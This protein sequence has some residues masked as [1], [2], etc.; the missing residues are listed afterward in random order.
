MEK[1]TTLDYAKFYVSKGFP[2][3]PCKHKDKQPAIPSWK[4]YQDRLPSDDELNS[5]FGN[6][7]RHNIAIITG[8]LSGIVAVDL[9]S[10]SAVEFAKSNNFPLSPLSKTGK[11]Y[12]IIYHY[13]DGVRNFQKRDDL[14]GIDLR[15]EGGYICVEPSIHPSGQHYK[16][17]TGKGLDDLPLAELPEMILAKRPEDKTPLKELYQGVPEGSRN[18]TLARLTGSWVNDGLSFDECLENAQIWNSK[19]EP[20]MAGRELHQTVRSIFERHQKTSIKPD[21]IQG[22]L[23]VTGIADMLNAEPVKYLID[24]ILVKD[25]LTMLSAYAATGK[26]LLS[27]AIAKATLTGD[28]LFDSL[29]VSETGP[30]LMIDEENPAAFIKERL[31]GF[32]FT[33]DMPLHFLH[34]QGIKLDND[35][36]FSELSGV[37]ENIKPILIIIDSL[38]RIHSQKENE[39]GMSYV[40]GRLRNLVQLGT[41]VLLIHHHRKGAGDIK[42]G[43]RGHSDIIGGVDMAITLEQKDDY[44]L[45]SHAKSRTVSHEPIRLE[46]Q[47]SGGALN[48]TCLGDENSELSEVIFSFLREH[49]E[50]MKQTEILKAI[51]ATGDLDYGDKK[52]RQ[53]L[54]KGEGVYWDSHKGGQTGKAIIYRLK[55]EMR[56]CGNTIYKGN[57][58]VLDKTSSKD[59]ATL[60]GNESLQTLDNTKCGNAAEGIANHCRITEIPNVAINPPIKGGNIAALDLDELLKDAVIISRPGGVVQ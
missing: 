42:E 50:G 52:I 4:E 16:W 5:W 13:K 30:V 45:L 36:L 2:V 34:Y 11:G 6:G 26:S 59:P 31:E 27:L 53:A 54:R 20:P 37:I 28:K 1:R 33:A 29:S 58:A 47:A 57:I 43:I 15:G 56:Q 40:M 39:A 14:P 44:L 21:S 7:S 38:I 24:R 41:T 17:E 18:D 60:G 19:N 12:H 22:R 49:P 32:G 35:S 48:Y 46:L 25:T 9:D 10:A 23:K 3:I 55:N 8:K 51:R